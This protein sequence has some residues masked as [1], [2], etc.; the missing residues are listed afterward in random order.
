GAELSADGL[1]GASAHERG[2]AVRKRMHED[3]NPVLKKIAD[4]PVPT[5]AA[6]NGIAAGGGYGVALCCDLVIA[7]ESASFVMVFTPQLGLIPDLSASWHAPRQ[8]GRA[9]AMAAAFFGDRMNAAQAVEDGLIWKAVPD[10]RLQAEVDNVAAHL[11]AGPT[12]A[13]REVRRAFDT[14]STHGL[15]AHLD[16]EAGHQPALIATDDFVEGV[17]AFLEKRKPAFSGK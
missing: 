17:L 16:Y 3:F 14:A 12:L 2:E 9:K 4:L 1:A 6:V 10:D 13:Y 5:I 11:A 7:A 8:L 15:H